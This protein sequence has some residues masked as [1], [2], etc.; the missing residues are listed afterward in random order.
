MTGEPMHTVSEMAPRTPAIS[1]IVQVKYP[2]HFVVSYV[3][4]VTQH[5]ESRTVRK[6]PLQST[7]TKRKNSAMHPNY[8]KYRL[9]V[10]YPLCFVVGY[11]QPVT[12]QYESRTV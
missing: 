10:K 6:A 11:V 5:F 2:L 9:K 4:P 3:Q 7:H 1:I 8:I 12:Q